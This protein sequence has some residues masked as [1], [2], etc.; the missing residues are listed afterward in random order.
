MKGKAFS[1][2]SWYPLLFMT[3][4]QRRSRMLP[5]CFTLHDKEVGG[6]QRERVIGMAAKQS[7]SE[8][9][10]ELLGAHLDTNERARLP[11]RGR[12][13]GRNPEGL[14]QNQPTF[15]VPFVRQSPRKSYGC[16]YCH[17]RAHE[18]LSAL[19]QLLMPSLRCV[20]A[21][22]RDRGMMYLDLYQIPHLF[23]LPFLHFSCD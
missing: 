20:T 5:P 21:D 6:P 11:K 7:R 22:V 8:R 3:A 13:V 18:V 14:G 15:C 19:C 12:I 1:S 4:G 23:S 9:C 17:G 10:G 16:C 2:T